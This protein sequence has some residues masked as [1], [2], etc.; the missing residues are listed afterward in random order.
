[1]GIALAFSYKTN[2]LADANIMSLI[3]ITWCLYNP[4]LTDDLRKAE[5]RKWV[6]LNNLGLVGGLIALK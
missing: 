4:F 3:L 1:M 6:A 2:C 5:H